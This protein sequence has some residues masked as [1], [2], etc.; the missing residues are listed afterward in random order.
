MKE[1]GILLLSVCAVT[2]LGSFFIKGLKNEKIGRCAMGVVALCALVL[3]TVALVRDF[4]EFE[5]DDG[6]ALDAPAGCEVSAERAFA[7]GIRKAVSVEFSVSEE[8]I[9]V[10]TEGFEFEQMRAEKIKVNITGAN[11]D[12]RGVRQYVNGLGIGEC[13]VNLFIE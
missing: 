3:P 5:F 6:G 10:L 7:I 9:S 1:Y 12:Y 2:A 11:V 8:K 4:S 13:E